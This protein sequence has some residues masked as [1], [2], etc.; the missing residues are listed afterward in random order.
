M[1]YIQDSKRDLTESQKKE[2]RKKEKDFAKRW[3]M[4]FGKKGS[5]E[6]S[7][8]KRQMIVTGKQT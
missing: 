7:S 6:N 8:T 4:A 3:E 2:I 5:N 1:K